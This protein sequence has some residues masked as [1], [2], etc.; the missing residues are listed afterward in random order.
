MQ[1][2]SEGN[3]YIYE[4]GAGCSG[5]PRKIPQGF[6]SDDLEFDVSSDS[7]LESKEVAEITKVEGNTVKVEN[8]LKFRKIAPTVMHRVIPQ[9]AKSTA[10]VAKKTR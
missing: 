4:P 3:L 10:I 8:P 2:D 1:F 9:K 6:S 5:R 7:S